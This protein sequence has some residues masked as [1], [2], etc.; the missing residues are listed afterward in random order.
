MNSEIARNL[1]STLIAK[2]DE[3]DLRILH[4]KLSRE[5]PTEEV[6]RHLEH[7]FKSFEVLW[8]VTRPGFALSRFHVLCAFY[9]TLKA[10]ALGRNISNKFNIEFLLRL[11]CEDQI[12][13]AL[14]AAGL[15]VKVKEFY[16][17]VLSFHKEVLEKSLLSLR[18]LPLED[19]KHIS[20]LE[21]Y[22]EEPYILKL[23]SVGLE[24]LSTTS[25]KSS[26]L[27]SKL[28][29]VLTRISLLNVKR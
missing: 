6:I 10:F 24:E 17:Y 21:Q 26:T 14:R 23:L 12:I 2:I 20:G 5:V 4:V 16:L 28:K 18:S 3:I 13:N 1:L 15:N 27:D 7:A 25:Y 9:H 8:A 19:F 29:S 22:E 11:T